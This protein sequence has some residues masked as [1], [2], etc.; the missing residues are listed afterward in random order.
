MVQ[1]LNKWNNLGENLRKV[2]IPAHVLVVLSIISMFVGNTTFWWLAIVY[3]VWFLLGHI[4]YGIFIHKY[5]C[6]KSFETQPW[7]ARTGIYLGML[8]GSGS[9]VMLKALHMSQH[10]PYSDTNEDPHTPKKGLSWSYFR[11]MSQKWRFKNIGMIKRLFRDPYIKFYHKF[12]YKI[13]WGTWIILALIDW[14]LAI[15]TMSWATFIEFHVNGFINTYGHTPHA[16]S[17][18]NYNV[19]DNSQ[20]IPWFNWITLGLGLH[21]NHHG[22]PWNYD[23][24]H[25]P[26]E[27]DFSK[28]FVPMI[29]E[30]KGTKNEDLRKSD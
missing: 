28:W 17:Y 13:Y 7:I 20:N 1:L 16:G 2:Y 15:F 27:I 25:R 29:S 8:S 3:P 10:H 23:Y 26:N 4:G 5:Y 18:Q 6:H 21:N 9:P 12:Y 11:W 24:A 30:K 22:Q 14:R 19:G